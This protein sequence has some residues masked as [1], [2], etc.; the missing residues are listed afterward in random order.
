[1][2]GVVRLVGARSRRPVRDALGE[3]E[4]QELRFRCDQRRCEE[5]RI[6]GGL[7]D[8][9]A[10]R[11]RADVQ[12]QENGRVTE[13]GNIIGGVTYTVVAVWSECASNRSVRERQPCDPGADPREHQRALGREPE[14][15]AEK[16][17]RVIAERAQRLLP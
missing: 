9:L 2:T 1:M 5:L 17:Q 13:K 4:R 10:D 16:I 11:D 15:R 6:T 14:R 7:L 12:A 3:G 8:A